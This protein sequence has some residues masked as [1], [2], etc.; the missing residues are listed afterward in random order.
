MEKAYK[1]IILAMDPQHSALAAVETVFNL[2]KNNDARVIVVDT[3]RPPTK[4]SLFFSSSAEDVF[5]MVIADKNDRIR[6]T[7][8]RFL[9]VGIEAEGKLLFGKSSEVITREAIDSKA[10]LVVRYMKGVQSRYPG[11]FGNTARNLMRVCP[12]PLLFVGN[13]PLENPKIMACVNAEHEVGENTVILKETR[14]LASKDE[15][16]TAIYCWRVAGHKYLRPYLS[17][18]AFNETINESETIHRN[19]FDQFCDQHR[20]GGVKDNLHFEYG[21]PTDVIPQVCRHESIDVAVMSSASQ[22][23]PVRRLLGST[24]EGVLD[25]LPC[26]LLV[27]KQ[28]GFESPVKGSPASEEIQHSGEALAKKHA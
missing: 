25:E 28:A 27:V 14:N 10:D 24:I 7:K 23:H 15:D 17:E 26:A 18:D 9:D 20:L 22:T 8:N 1:T 3:V 4:S 16:W 6:K 12:C 19:L 2:A 5:E 13:K 11:L 21:D